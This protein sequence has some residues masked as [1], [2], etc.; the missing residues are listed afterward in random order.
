MVDIT[1]LLF[2]ACILVSIV[3]VSGS[4]AHPALVAFIV[5]IVASDW[6]SM[7]AHI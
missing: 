1:G 3:R 7:L 5:T 4:W 2:V 6:L